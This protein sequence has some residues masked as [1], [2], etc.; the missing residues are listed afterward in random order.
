M[1]S[2]EQIEKEALEEGMA[3][4]RRRIKEKILEE[5]KKEEKKSRQRDGLFPPQ[6]DEPHPPSGA[7]DHDPDVRGEH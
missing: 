3:L 2:L 1:K 4:T 7:D 6:P 5:R